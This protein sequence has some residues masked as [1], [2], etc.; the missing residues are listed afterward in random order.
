MVSFSKRLLYLILSKINNYTE[1][2]I[3]KKQTSINIP[4]AVTYI[5]YFV[6]WVRVLRWNWLIYNRK[7]K[8]DQNIFL[9]NSSSKSIDIGIS[10]SYI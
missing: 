4:N 1:N 6:L 3:K 10:L 5:T 7:L 2:Q 8:R 9:L